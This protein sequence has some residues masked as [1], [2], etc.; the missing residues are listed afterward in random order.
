MLGLVFFN[1]VKYKE[2]GRREMSASLYSLLPETTATQ[3]AKEAS[4]LQSH[5]LRQVLLW[6][7]GCHGDPEVTGSLVSSCRSSTEKV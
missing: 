6:L 7:C 3:H 2:D 1:Q 5:V 4:E